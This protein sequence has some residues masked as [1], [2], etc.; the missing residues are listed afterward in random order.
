MIHCLLIVYAKWGHRQYVSC[1]LHTPPQPSWCFTSYQPVVPPLVFYLSAV[2]QDVSP[3]VQ[4]ERLWHAV[5][6]QD[7]YSV[8][9]FPSICPGRMDR[10]PGAASGALSFTCHNGRKTCTPCGRLGGG[11]V[12]WGEM[13]SVIS[14]LGS[15]D[16]VTI[17]K[18]IF[19]LFC[20]R[21]AFRSSVFKTIKRR[22]RKSNQRLFS[23]YVILS[24]LNLFISALIYEF[25][26]TELD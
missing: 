5:P 16:K 8:D 9:C 4:D 7:V 13:C 10:W 15:C 2:A 21:F 22:R 17:L 26:D 25:C 14:A 20:A 24:Q 3:G 12:G 19:W 6:E 11:G 18:V 23:Y 1:Q